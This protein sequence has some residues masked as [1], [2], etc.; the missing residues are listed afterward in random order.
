MNS[1]RNQSYPDISDVLELKAQARRQNARRPYVEKLEIVEKLRDG[2]VAFGRAR[3]E[4]GYSRS[5]EQS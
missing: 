1:S 4:R 3:K 5:R 2:L